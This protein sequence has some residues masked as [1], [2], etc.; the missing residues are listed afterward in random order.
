MVKHNPKK[1][2]SIKSTTHT[3]NYNKDD[4]FHNLDDR[5]TS[6]NGKMVELWGLE[7]VIKSLVSSEVCLR[8]TLQ[9]MIFPRALILSLGALSPRG[10]LH[11]AFRTTGISCVHL[12]WKC[13]ITLMSLFT[14][15]KWDIHQ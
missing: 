7:L 4:V 9:E 8:F 11:M 12:Y 14:P 1:N 2:K 5:H 6:K 15:Q 3:I 13:V 10:V